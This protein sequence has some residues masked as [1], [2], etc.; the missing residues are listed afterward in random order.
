MM[1]RLL[2][3]DLCQMPKFQ[4]ELAERPTEIEFGNRAVG[5]PFEETLRLIPKLEE[6]AT[7][8]LIQEE[9]Y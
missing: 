9:G 3:A 2:E 5:R 7:M 4:I 6:K 8:P 1:S